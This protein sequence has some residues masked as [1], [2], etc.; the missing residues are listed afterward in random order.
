MKTQTRL[1]RGFHLVHDLVPLFRLKEAIM[2]ANL[3]SAAK[4]RLEWFDYYR[5]SGNVSQTCRYFGI[6]RETFY[7]WWKRYNPNDLSSL[8]DKDKTPKHKR[9]RAISPEIEARVV[10]LRRQFIRY[11]KIKLALKYEMLYG[12]KI[13]S[14]QIQKIIE[15]YGLYYNPKK[16]K[17]IAS[18]RRRA[19]KK[20]RITELQKKS[21]QTGFLLCIDAIVIYWNGMRRYI[22][23]AIDHYSKMAYARMYTTKSS[24]SAADFLN[25]L[26]FLFEG[27]I[28]N[29]Q[30]DNGS[31]FQKCFAQACQQLKLEHYFSRPKTPKDNAV[32]ERFNRTL[33]DEFL[34]LGNFNHNPLIFNRNLTEWLIEYDF[35]RPHETLGYQTPIQVASQNSHLSGM[36]SSSTSTLL[37][38]NFVIIY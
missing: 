9:Q 38:H 7:E 32:N 31:E 36:Y 19:V 35:G 18:K 12:K 17:R 16:T 23:T 11:G 5:K 24:L 21:R 30:T 28:E 4:R 3:S 1:P 26:W 10:A 13:T 25:R 33:E 22:F 2:R 15:K 14:W 29:I 20:K 27:Q 34:N 6:A 37:F 8:E